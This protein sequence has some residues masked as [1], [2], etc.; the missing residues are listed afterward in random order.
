MGTC[1]LQARDF[2]LLGFADFDVILATG[3]DEAESPWERFA[4]T[5]AI[6]VAPAYLG[7]LADAVPRRRTSS[8]RTRCST[9]SRPSPSPGTSTTQSPAT[10][11]AR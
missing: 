8:S 1:G 9:G 3:I 6:E 11:R 10:P 7:E 5:R 4:L 2:E